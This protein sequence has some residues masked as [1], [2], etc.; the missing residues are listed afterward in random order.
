MAKHCEQNWL[1]DMQGLATVTTIGFHFK[2]ISMSRLHCVM[3]IKLVM[4]LSFSEG[5]HI[6]GPHSPTSCRAFLQ[7]VLDDLGL[8]IVA[9]IFSHHGAQ[10]PELS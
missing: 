7:E 3:P 8:C 10:L 5:T 9:R 1:Y 4:A 2:I 6:R